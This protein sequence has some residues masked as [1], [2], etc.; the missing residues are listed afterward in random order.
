M[1]L[2]ALSLIAAACGRTHPDPGSTQVVARV[3]N[4]EI[5][6]LQFNAALAQVPNVTAD[7]AKAA[8]GPLL[9][10]LIDQELLVQKAQDAKLDRSPQV[11]QAMEAAKRQVLASAYLQQFIADV[12]KPTDQDIHAYFVQH[13]EYF[14]ARR[15]YTYRSIPVTAPASEV[16]AIEHQLSSS[17]D[18]D[19]VIA[20]LRA[21][22]VT[23]A[24]NSETKAAEQLPSE[25]V[26]KLA[27]LKDGQTA[28]FPFQGGVQ[29]VQLVS[30]RPEPVGEVQARPFIENFLLERSRRERAD[31][32]IKSLR[33]LASIQYTCELK[34]PAAK[35]ADSKPSANDVT[36]SI[37]TGLK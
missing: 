9:E 4:K 32:E 14:D 20:T 16:Q 29:I 13:P 27:A 19:A 15:V 26:P 7:T 22:K 34:A 8:S 18:V 36:T 25:V 24:V 10:R 35:A 21:D 23:F 2:L 33:S 5:T 17:Q 11:A 28:T 31:S 12:P 3:N 30:S 1:G 6:I 37:A